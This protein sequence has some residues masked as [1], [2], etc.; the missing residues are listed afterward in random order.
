MATQSSRHC[1]GTQRRACSALGFCRSAKYEN[2]GLTL[3]LPTNALR[4]VD[5]PF[6]ISFVAAAM[7]DPSERKAR[8][9]ALRHAKAVAT[10]QAPAAPATAQSSS[11]SFSSSS[12]SSSSSAALGEKR[13]A[14]SSESAVAS[15]AAGAAQA[16]GERVFDGEDEILEVEDMAELDSEEYVLRSW[17]FAAL[18]A[19]S[20]E[21]GRP[22]IQI[23]PPPPLHTPLAPVRRF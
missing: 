23:T 1:R 11:S 7:E 18:S 14:A 15:A 12:S 3:G 21:N 9:A 20:R 17:S 16:D 13:K 8:L 4:L 10:G 22:K 19:L 2:S 6:G 5:L